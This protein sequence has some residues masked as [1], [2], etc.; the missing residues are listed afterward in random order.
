MSDMREEY[1][2][3]PYCEA[4]I[5][6]LVFRMIET[7]EDRFS[8]SKMM[9]MQLEI[10][11]LHDELEGNKGLDTAKKLLY[12]NRIEHIERQLAHPV[13]KYRERVY[14]C[15]ECEKLLTIVPANDINNLME[16]LSSAAF[17]IRNLV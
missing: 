11:H 6:H 17:D 10:E 14:H 7:Q 4:R 8:D 2:I 1:V 5:S 16:L 15:P 3:C 12:K 9:E 13:I